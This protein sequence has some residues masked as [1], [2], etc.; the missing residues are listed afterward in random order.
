MSPTRQQAMI[1]SLFLEPYHFSN[2]FR[3]T[4]SPASSPACTH[5][6]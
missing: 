1:K 3:E 5:G 6:A 2:V 4:A